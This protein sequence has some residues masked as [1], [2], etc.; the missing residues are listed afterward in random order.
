[1]AGIGAV[2]CFLDCLTDIWR[3]SPYWPRGVAFELDIWCEDLSETE[4]GDE[5][6]RHEGRNLNH[7]RQGTMWRKGWRESPGI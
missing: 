6:E 5:Q 2:V 3:Y 4:S 1:M 7:G